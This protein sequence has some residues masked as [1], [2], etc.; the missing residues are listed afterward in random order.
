MTETV[1][2]SNSD[3]MYIQALKQNLKDNGIATDEFIKL[4]TIRIISENNDYS[5]Q[6]KLKLTDAV[7]HGYKVTRTPEEIIRE[8]FASKVGKGWGEGYRS[9]MQY[10]IKKTLDTLGIQIKGVNVDD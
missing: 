4:A 3:A 8:V 6:E 5:A 2:I 7:L 9:G 10:G 1:N